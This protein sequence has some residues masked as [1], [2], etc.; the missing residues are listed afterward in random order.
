MAKEKEQGLKSCSLDKARLKQLC[1]GLILLICDLGIVQFLSSSELIY[2]ATS[3]N[4]FLTTRIEG[5]AFGANI[6]REAFF[7]GASLECFATGAFNDALTVLRMDF[8]FHY[9]H[10]INPETVPPA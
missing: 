3:V 10:L 9:L 5:V 6:Y 8:F 1:L 4:Q 7:G 2:T